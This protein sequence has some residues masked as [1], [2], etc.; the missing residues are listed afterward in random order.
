MN[1]HWFHLVKKLLCV[2]GVLFSLSLGSTTFTFRGFQS[3]AMDIGPPTD[4]VPFE[5]AA[6][7]VRTLGFF[8]LSQTHRTLKHR[9]NGCHSRFEQDI[10]R[11]T[12][13]RVQ[14]VA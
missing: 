9:P 2:R 5:E 14:H 12:L 10:C 11:T 7:M 13:E 1:S 4:A 8:S 3:G 6:E